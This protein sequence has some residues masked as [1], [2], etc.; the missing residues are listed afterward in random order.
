M[1]I[2]KVRS[3]NVTMFIALHAYAVSIYYFIFSPPLG[4]E[5]PRSLGDPIIVRMCF[6]FI[7]GVT[8]S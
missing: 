4:W 5:R 8:F 3:S 7:R 2:V 6:L 1:C